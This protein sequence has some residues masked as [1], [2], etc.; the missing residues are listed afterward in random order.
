[1]PQII[2]QVSELR[3]TTPE[4]QRV[5]EDVHL[6]LDRG[7]L[8]CIVGE[9]SSGKSLLFKLLSKEVEPQRGQILV[10]DRNVTRIR[11]DRL[12][13]LRRR[14]GIVPQHPK[15]MTGRTIYEALLLKLRVMGY[16]ASD[17]QRKAVDTLEAIKL[18]GLR[19]MPISDLSPA[20]QKLFQ[21]A[22]AACHE[23]GI[24]LIDEPFAGLEFKDAQHVVSGL[25]HFH[26]R[27]HLAVLLATRERSLA[28]QTGGRIVFLRDGTIVDAPPPPAPVTDDATPRRRS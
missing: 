3:F 26:E 19:E 9:T 11:P 21:I 17:A 24:L 2:I 22:L 14:M 5:L 25:K 13:Q 23:P 6:R 1:M 20:N 27:K 12:L 18:A 4:G 28:Q 10:D 7:E 8:V 15:P 16:E